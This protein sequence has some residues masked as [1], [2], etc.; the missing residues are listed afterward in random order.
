[1]FGIFPIFQ[2]F[3]KNF[4]KCFLVFFPIVSYFSG[5]LF[6]E[7]IRGVPLPSL[8]VPN[9]N[10]LGGS[11]GFLLVFYWISIG[12]LLDFFILGKD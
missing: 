12:F 11:I 6:W 9:R 10:P 4:S 3:Y 5:F 2:Y 7:R 8:M 1:M